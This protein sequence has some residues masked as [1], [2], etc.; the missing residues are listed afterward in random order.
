MGISTAL[1]V[2]GHIKPCGH[3]DTVATEL[4][5]LAGAS[6]SAR[7]VGLYDRS[8]P[9]GNDV[10]SVAPGAFIRDPRDVEWGRLY[11]TTGEAGVFEAAGHPLELVEFARPGE[12]T[13]VAILAAT[14]AGYCVIGLW[15]VSFG[16]DGAWNEGVEF[17]VDPEDHGVSTIT[18][19]YSCQYHGLVEPK[20]EE[21]RLVLRTDGHHLW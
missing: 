1:E 17:G 4:S 3:L 11:T 7:N 2:V 13:G 5:E 20:D 16:G 21:H 8:Y 19:D 6:R 18:V 12:G 9:H 10:L 15:V 14:H